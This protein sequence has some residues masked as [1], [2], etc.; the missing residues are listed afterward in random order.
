M[1]LV[2]LS[3]ASQQQL[4]AAALQSHQLQL[5]TSP[6][7]PPLS[8]RCVRCCGLSAVT[9]A[10]R[11]QST[12]PLLARDADTLMRELLIPI[13][14]ASKCAYKAQQPVL[15][16]ASSSSTGS[17]GG[18]ITT[19]SSITIRSSSNSFW[20]PLL[21]GGGGGGGSTAISACAAAAAAATAP[22]SPP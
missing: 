11:M 17:D 13:F 3:H 2:Q 18:G 14:V 20:P 16:T 9:E 21:G 7:A 12:V 5:L 6:P 22:F 1:A 15:L 8:R 10:Q 19:Q 4:L